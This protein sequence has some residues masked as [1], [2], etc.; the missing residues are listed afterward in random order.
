MDNGG[1]APLKKLFAVIAVIAVLL[2]ISLVFAGCVPTPTPTATPPPNGDDKPAGDFFNLYAPI[3]LIVVIIALGVLMRR[4]RGKSRLEVAVSL[5]SDVGKNLK[6]SDVFSDTRRSVKKF[7]TGSWKKYKDKIDFL[8]VALQKNLA[9][10]FELAEGFNQRI[11]EAKKQ[12]ST[13][14]LAG[15]S[16]DKMKEPLTKSKQG[17]AEWVQA[18]FQTEMKQRRG[19]GLFGGGLFR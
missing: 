18:N 10:A 19:G 7:R 8:D 14:Y 5:L 9:S 15:I 13:A 4:R 17:L 2:V 16:V 11:D 3:I 1:T 12:K 6:I